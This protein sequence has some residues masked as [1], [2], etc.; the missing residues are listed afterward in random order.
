M[1]LQHCK[2]KYNGIENLSFITG[3]GLKIDFSDS[4]DII[5]TIH[6]MEHIIDDRMFLKNLQKWMKKNAIIILEVPLLMK[7][8]FINSNEPYGDDHIREYYTNDLIE[9]FSSYFKVKDA[10]GV[11]RG[12]YTELEMARNAVL[13][14]GENS[15]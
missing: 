6:T 14:V 5:V 9:L 15:L 8:P 11:S 2:A 4:F 7:Y 10:Y 13:L 1:L 3:D 12:F